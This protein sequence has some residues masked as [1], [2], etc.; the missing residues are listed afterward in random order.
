MGIVLKKF[1]TKTSDKMMK[2]IPLVLLAMNFLTFCQGAPQNGY[3]RKAGSCFNDRPQGRCLW[4]D[5]KDENGVVYCFKNEWREQW[6]LGVTTCKGYNKNKPGKHQRRVFTD[7][8]FVK[9]SPRR[10][11]QGAIDP[12]AENGSDYG[13]IDPFAGLDG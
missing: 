5:Y 13:A 2:V 6:N 7:P 10:R 1:G 3:V 12:W 4:D 9:V 11:N 8:D